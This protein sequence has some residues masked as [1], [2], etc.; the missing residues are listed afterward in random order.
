[1]SAL[2][3][4]DAS[5]EVKDTRYFSESGDFFLKA[6]KKKKNVLREGKGSS[7]FVAT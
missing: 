3:M 4:L 5:G 1:M 2:L 7:F 6:V